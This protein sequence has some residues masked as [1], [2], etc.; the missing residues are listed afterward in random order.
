M[1]AEARQQDKRRTDLRPGGSKPAAQLTADRPQAGAPETL[2]ELSNS[3]PRAAQLRSY[4]AMANHATV[5]RQADAPACAPCANKTG[6][7]DQLKAGVESLS[8]MSLD[9][10]RVHYNSAQPA[11][12]NAL[13]YAQGRDIH[14]APGQERH[15][16]HEAWHIVQQAQ[17]RVRPT[18]QLKHG[19]PVND[20]AGL[21]HEADVMGARAVLGGD[22]MPQ[23]RVPIPAAGVVAQR[24]IASA[25]GDGAEQVKERLAAK[26]VPGHVVD[27][28]Q[29]LLTTHTEDE[30]VL[31][32]AG[33]AIKKPMQSSFPKLIRTADDTTSAESSLIF[34]GMSVN[35]VK[36]LKHSVLEQDQD[37]AIFSA[38]MPQGDATPIDHIVDDFDDSPFLSFESG[39]YNISAG[40]YAP[41][42]THADTRKP[43][44]VSNTA[45]GFL[46][47]KPSYTGETRK[48]YPDAK[49][50]GYFGGINPAYGQILDVSTVELATQHLVDE[51][52]QERQDNAR[53]IAVNDREVLVTPGVQGIPG[54]RLP[55]VGK[56]QAVTKDYYN[57]KKT[58]QTAT[59]ALGFFKPANTVAAK[60]DY[61]KVQIAEKYNRDK[62]HAFSIPEHERK[63]EDDD[64]SDISDVESIDLDLSAGDFSS[65]EEDVQ[66]D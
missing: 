4:A 19:V 10:V 13:A 63:R 58:R 11:Q 26:E 38:Q 33:P 56:V 54:S 32:H 59:K 49:R 64:S 9:N 6:M 34:R 40:K 51:E 20:D 42:P 3:S 8:G 37:S 7:P 46:K 23:D 55:F 66:Q 57:K 15:L 29:A 44:G 65:N 45:A 36:N 61:F 1:R 22:F 60:T 25:N 21:E 28:Y 5:Q 35:N 53:R 43:R 30:V 16:P 27:N 14:L 52:H 18:M 48:A 39:S 41:K 31:A 47:Q 50:I 62:V 17:G 2:Q 12:L 24:V